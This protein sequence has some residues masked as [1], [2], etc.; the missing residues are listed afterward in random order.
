METLTFV[1]CADLHLGTAFKGID[2]KIGRER[3]KELMLSLAAIVDICQRQQADVLFIAGDLWQ[4][5]YVTRPLV[6]FISDQFRR[7]PQV[8]VVIAPG[9][10][11]SYWQ[12]SYY[13]AFSWPNNVHIFSGP[14][15]SVY[16]SRLNLRVHGLAWTGTQA[17]TDQAERLDLAD[18]KQAAQILIAHGDPEQLGLQS[19][20][21][22]E[23][24]AYIALGHNHSHSKL[25]PAVV[26]PGSPEPLSFSEEGRHGI[27]LGKVGSMTLHTEFIPLARRQ[28]INLSLELGPD[29]A[30][31]AIIEQVMQIVRPFEPETNMISLT[32]TGQHGDSWSLAA[33]EE[34]L[35]DFWYCRVQDNTTPDIDAN[36]LLAEHRDNLVGQFIAAL[37]SC[38]QPPEV[39]KRALSYGLDALLT[40]GVRIW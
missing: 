21:E 37:D 36:A 16:F 39:K 19:A 35:N 14:L 31:A 5:E 9:D 7:I 24:L 22:D 33:V 3:R 25:A 2:P 30:M 32:L 17:P 11:D 15:T 4:Q 10:A 18:H 29:K 27:V 8:Q 23:R 40:R 20:L 6:E 26:Y 38:E 13:S 34:A 1:H 28:C 12:G